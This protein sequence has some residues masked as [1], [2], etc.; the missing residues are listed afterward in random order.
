MEDK[1]S[2]DLVRGETVNKKHCLFEIYS[3][4][5]HEFFIILD[6][7]ISGLSNCATLY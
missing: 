7:P 2:L 3:L 6:R 4:A 1:G 5:D